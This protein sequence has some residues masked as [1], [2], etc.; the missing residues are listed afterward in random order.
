MGG[1]P[2]EVT[3]AYR[4]GDVRHIVASPERARRELGFGAGVSF[5]DGMAGFARAPLR[6]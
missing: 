6:T 2:P 4:A 1:P 5:A 3:G